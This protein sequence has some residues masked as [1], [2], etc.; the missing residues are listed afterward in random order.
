MPAGKLIFSQLTEWIHPEQF[1]RCVNR[2][3]GNYKIR[4]FPCWDQFLAMTFAQVTYR[5]SLADIEVCLRSRPDQLYQM[6][7]RSAVAHSTLADANSRVTGASMPTWRKCSS[8]APADCMPTNHWRGVGPNGLRLGFHDHR[9]VPELVSL[10]AFS[11]GPRR[12]SSSTPCWICAGPFP[13]MI[14]ISEENR[15]MCISWTS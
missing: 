8:P 7:F 15:P 13:R 14:S 4:N 3:D 2:Y 12:P 10:G 9:P 1:R 11:L 5:E 6:G